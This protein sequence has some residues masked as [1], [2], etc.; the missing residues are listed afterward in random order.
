MFAVVGDQQY[1]NI[2]P[3]NIENHNNW[4]DKTIEALQWLKEHE[5]QCNPSITFKY[6]FLMDNIKALNCSRHRSIC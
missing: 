6:A 4:Q 5:V 1:F 3:Y 2:N